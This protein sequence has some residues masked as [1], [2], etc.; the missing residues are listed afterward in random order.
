M[1]HIYKKI[2]FDSEEELR[3]YH[4]IEEAVENKVIES[5]IY[6]PEPI[7]LIENV[8]HTTVS[9][10][11]IKKSCKF[12]KRV[13]LRNLEYTPDFIIKFNNKLLLLNNDITNVEG[14][15]GSYWMFNPEN[16]NSTFDMIIDVKSSVSNQ[17]G[18]NST[19]ITFPI[20]QKMLWATKGIYVHK[21]VPDQW[22]KQFWIPER[23]AYKQNRILPV[24]TKLGELCKTLKELKGET[25]WESS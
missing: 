4:W 9:F 12:G 13:M 20:K 21:V 24:K 11:K 18:N 8:T 7:V 14:V 25:E 16:I 1:K 2:T 3:L 6:H 23:Y 19:A 10:S 17:Y 22:F 5:F 15:H